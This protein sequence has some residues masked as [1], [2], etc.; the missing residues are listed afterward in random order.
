MKFYIRSDEELVEDTKDDFEPTEMEQEFTSERTSINFSKV[1]AVFKYVN[2]WRAGTLNLDYGGGRA[3]TAQ[4]YLSKYDVINLVY[5]PYNRTPEHNKEVIKLVKEH[6][7]ADTATCSNV[8]NV[9]KEPEVRLN[10]LKNIKKLV[11]SSGEVYITVYEGTGKGDEG[12]TKSGYQLNRKTADYLEEIQQVFPDAKR[13][14]KLIVAHPSGSV[15]SSVKAAYYG[16]AF[17]IDP[18]E[19]FTK[20]EIVEFGYDVADKVNEAIYRQFGESSE[21]DLEDTYVEDYNCVVVELFD[22]VA[23]ITCSGQATIDMRRI[24]KP[25]DLYKYEATIVDQIVSA[26]S[27]YVGIVASTKISAAK[28][29]STDMIIDQSSEIVAGTVDGLEPSRYAEDYYSK[30]PESDVETVTFPFEFMVTMSDG[31]Q[32]LSYDSDDTPW[33]EFSD[34]ESEIY[35]GTFL[36]NVEAFDDEFRNHVIDD[37]PEEDGQ[38]KISGTFVAKYHIEYFGNDEYDG[39]NIQ[40]DKY[41]SEFNIEN[42]NVEKV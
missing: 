35:P 19:F 27:E 23:G 33:G 39:P 8:L 41:Q 6:G 37:L 9:I 25:R 36:D 4:D 1:P 14:G 32:T 10:V 2:N 40:V 15:S 3:D 26:Y 28:Q 5:D 18:H 21:F 38:Y 7:G 20:E 31:G 42:L 16:G 34:I 29:P 11:K 30:T 22:K 17:D 12:A 24:R 13:K